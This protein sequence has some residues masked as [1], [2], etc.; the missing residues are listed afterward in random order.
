MSAPPSV[1][2]PPGADELEAARHL[3]P[4]GLLLNAPRPHLLRFMPALT[5]TAAEI[6]RMIELLREALAVVAATAP[7]RAA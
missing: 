1:R 6:D 2:W 5:V 4:V 7:S 3:Q